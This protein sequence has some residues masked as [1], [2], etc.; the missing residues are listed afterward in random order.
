[1]RNGPGQDDQHR[2]HAQGQ[3]QKAREAYNADV[4][5]SPGVHTHMLTSADSIG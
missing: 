2:R 5:E 4:H 1:M 3:T